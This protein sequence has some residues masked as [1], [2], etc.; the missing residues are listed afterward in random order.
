MPDPE[1]REHAQALA[2]VLAL[3]HPVPALVHAPAQAAPRLP[4]R[5]LARS[6]R[7]PEAAADAR[8]IRRPKKAQ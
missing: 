4:A 8:S 2:R 7:L 5:L 1:L 6:A 3:A